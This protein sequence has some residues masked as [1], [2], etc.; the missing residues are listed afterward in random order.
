MN[1]SGAARPST[2]VGATDG[3]GATLATAAL[4]AL[5]VLLAAPFAAASQ[6]APVG[7]VAPTPEVAPSPL[8][9]SP[10]RAFL[11]ALLIPGWGHA[12]IGS[13]GRGGFY[14]TAQAATVYTALRARRRIGEAQDRVR[15]QEQNIRAQLAAE[16]I[17]DAEAIQT[18]LDEDGTLGD[19]NNLLDSR[20]E[21]Q[22]DL[23]ALSLFLILI[24]GVDAYVS[25]HLARFPEP[26]DVGVTPTETGGVEVGV[27]IPIG[28]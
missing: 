2:A 21:Q 5:V 12:A 6:V 28:R 24:S 10:G 8:G 3:R 1:R 15:F 4:V 27:S 26:L 9:I 17:T 14:F 11:R 23:V 13:Y 16:G 22:E 18:R 20:Q 19:L 7:P 25:A